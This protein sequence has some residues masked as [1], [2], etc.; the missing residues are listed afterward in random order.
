VIF[1]QDHAVLWQTPE[2]PAFLST[3]HFL[4]YHLCQLSIKDW[5]KKLNIYTLA[6]ALPAF[7]WLNDFAPLV[8]DPMKDYSQVTLE[9]QPA[10]APPQ[11][12]DFGLN[13]PLLVPQ[14][15]TLGANTVN[16]L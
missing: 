8:I 13:K 15:P 1:Q 12:K 9:P 2:I 5:L 4:S 6:D 16:R 14:D 7:P 10:T 11:D 3:D